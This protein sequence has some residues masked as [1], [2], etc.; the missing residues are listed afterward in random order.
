MSSLAHTENTWKQLGRYATAESLQRYRRD[1]SNASRMR[2][3]ARSM[4]TAPKIA[5]MTATPWAPAATTA[6]T[7]AWS[8]PPMAMAGIPVGASL[9]RRLN[10]S[11]LRGGP[12]WALLWVG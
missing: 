8:I 11:G 1:P 7:L 5:L 2:R 9:A 4:S 6:D 10:P 3:V 12:A